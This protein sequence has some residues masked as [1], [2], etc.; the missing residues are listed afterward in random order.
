MKLAGYK[1]CRKNE[2]FFNRKTTLVAA[3]LTT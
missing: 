3:T 2:I 1:N